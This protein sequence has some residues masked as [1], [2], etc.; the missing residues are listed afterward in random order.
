M[1]PRVKCKKEDIVSVAFEIARERGPQALTAREVASKMGISTQPIFTCFSSMDELK[2]AVYARAFGFFQNY[3]GEG[4]KQDVPFLGV[5][6]QYIHF[7]KQEKELFK[8][9]FLDKTENACIRAGDALR[10]AQEFVLESVMKNYNMDKDTAAHFIRNLWVTSVSLAVM[11][12]TDDCPFTDEDI[13][14]IF[15]EMSLSLCKTY[16]EIP[17]MV[18][19]EYDKDAIFDELVGKKRR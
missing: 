15:A 4:L 16:K 10:L 3:L 12:V 5:G 17:G 7:A 1:P 18:K 11:L 19:G 9:L 8:M 2:S 6:K 14:A 13:G